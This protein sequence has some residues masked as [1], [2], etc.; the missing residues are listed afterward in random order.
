LTFGDFVVKGT[1]FAESGRDILFVLIRG[2]SYTVLGAWLASY[3]KRCEFLIIDDTRNDRAKQL[4]DGIVASLNPTF[5]LSIETNSRLLL[6]ERVS[7]ISIVG[8]TE[9]LSL[10]VE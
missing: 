6:L 5:Y 4:D 3:S 7:C 9:L 8:T 10:E 1:T 2:S